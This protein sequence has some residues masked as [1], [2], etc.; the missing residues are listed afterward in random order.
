M[1]WAAEST[2][3]RDFGDRAGRTFYQRRRAL[4]NPILQKILHRGGLYRPLKAAQAFPF[5]DICC[6]GNVRQRD[7]ASIMLLNEGEHLANAKIA[8]AGFRLASRL[9]LELLIQGKTQF[10]QIVPDGKFKAGRIVG[11][12]VKGADK[13]MQRRRIRLSPE[14]I[15]VKCGTGRQRK[16]VFLTDMS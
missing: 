14:D 9:R 16:D 1:A 13:G 2:G 4:H 10:R 3:E 8:L 15:S 12:R 11:Q 7:V 5:A 6:S